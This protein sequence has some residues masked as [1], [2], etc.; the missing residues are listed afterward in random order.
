MAIREN[1]SIFK[2]PRHGRASVAPWMLLA[3]LAVLAAAGLYLYD[4]RQ[5]EQVAALRAE[6]TRLKSAVDGAAAARKAMEGVASKQVAITGGQFTGLW[7]VIK[8]LQ[9]RT[10][11]L[12]A[13]LQA[14]AARTTQSAASADARAASLLK[15]IAALRAD[16]AAM[17]VRLSALETRGAAPEPAVPPETRPKPP[18]PV[19][20]KTQP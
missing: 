20:P 3:L 8:A 5:A 18:A 6:L 12:E 15:D 14:Q 19:A 7:R 10:G 11:K 9:D 2:K 17:L 4:K 13:D 1:R 16:M